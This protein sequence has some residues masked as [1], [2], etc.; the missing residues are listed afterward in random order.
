MNYELFEKRLVTI[1]RSQNAAGI[2]NE[3]N[4]GIPGSSAAASYKS[5]QLERLL[6]LQQLT[7]QFPQEVAEESIPAH[8]NTTAYNGAKESDM[9]Q[10]TR[11]TDW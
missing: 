8:I 11:I 5:M 7:F 4:D 6:Q 1:L 3:L 9:H 10:T 2:P